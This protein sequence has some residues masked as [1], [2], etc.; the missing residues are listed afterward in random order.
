MREAIT[1]SLG[2]A[3]A[4][5][6]YPGKEAGAGP[7]LTL[8]VPSDTDGGVHS[9][10]ESITIWSDESVIALRDFLNKIFPFDAAKEGK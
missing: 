9:P 5:Y 4:K 1:I 6:D 2:W 10:A 7:K 3:V 8:L